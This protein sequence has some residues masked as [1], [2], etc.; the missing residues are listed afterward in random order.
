MKL[1]VYNQKGESVNEVELD[2]RIF[3]VKPDSH[4]MAEVV[5][6]QLLSARSSTAH[7]KTRG[8]VRGGG[9]K[10]WK[11]KGTGRARVGSTRSPIWRHG[12]ITFGPRSNRNWEVKVNKKLK[13]K[14]LFMSLSDKAKNN[15]IMLF[16]N[17]EMEKAKTRLFA[18]F[19]QNFRKAVKN[20]GKKV[21]LV[22]PK[23]N[24]N[25]I[26]SSRN[27]PNVEYIFAK[28]LNIKEVLDAD[29]LFLPTESLEVIAKTFKGE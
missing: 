10:P 4:V 11:Q 20:V 5:R 23:K 13:K 8:E 27:L 6:A 12:G 21:L 18:M 29:T 14:A 7:T 1:P 3:G 19:L 28:N 26:K 15:S 24:E 25:I 22:L 16:E 9:K 17:I 2:S